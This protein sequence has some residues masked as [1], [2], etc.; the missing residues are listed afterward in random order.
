MV[1][2]PR[3]RRTLRE[4]VE[5]AGANFA[6]GPVLRPRDRHVRDLRGKMLRLERK[7]DQRTNRLRLASGALPD[8]HK[9]SAT[10]FLRVPSRDSRAEVLLKQR[11]LDGELI[12]ACI[13][14]G[15]LVSR[16]FGVDLLIEGNRDIVTI[17]AVTMRTSQSSCHI[18]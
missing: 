12:F 11:P 10:P 5:I 6:A 18:F 13:A 14:A 2:G 17:E 16:N 3:G 15:R 4:Q 8:N 1:F 9:L 7:P